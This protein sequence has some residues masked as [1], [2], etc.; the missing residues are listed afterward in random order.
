MRKLSALRKSRTDWKRVR[1]LKD[2]QIDFSDM[3]EFTAGMFARA[4]VRQG[5]KP[6]SRK[7]HLAMLRNHT[8]HK[9]AGSLLDIPDVDAG[10]PR[11]EIVD[12]VR[13]SRR[14]TG[15]LRIRV[16]RSTG[17]R[18]QSKGSNRRPLKRNR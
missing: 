8:Q 11:E 16:A 5:L 6:L 1:A 14:S 10:L 15:R 7:V 18:I 12:L 17:T 4:V 13:E 9:D 2:D 3:P